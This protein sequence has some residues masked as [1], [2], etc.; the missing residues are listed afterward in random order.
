MCAGGRTI[1]DVHDGPDVRAAADDARAAA[2]GERAR[3][4]WDGDRVPV[5][6]AGAGRREE[7]ARGEAEDEAREDE[8]RA[9]VAVRGRAERE[10]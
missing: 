10:S 6:D 9:R 7:R 1:R 3:E 2:R 8:V 5:R 4:P